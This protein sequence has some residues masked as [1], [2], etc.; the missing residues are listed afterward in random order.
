MAWNDFSSRRVSRRGMDQ[1]AGLT[2]DLVETTRA[3][4][5]DHAREHPKRNNGR[6]ECPVCIDAGRR[7]E[8]ARDHA[9]GLLW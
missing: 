9:A 5:L 2:L 3:L 4:L 8:A 1:G 7:I 6:L